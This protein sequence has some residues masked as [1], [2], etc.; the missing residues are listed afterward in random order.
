[1]AMLTEAA[2]PA[3]FWPYA[4]EAYT[5]V[6]NRTCTSALEPTKTPFEIWYGRKPDVSHLRVFGSLAYT[7][8]PADLRKSFDSHYA[9]AICLGYSDTKPGC[10]RFYNAEKGVH[11]E[12]SQAVFD[13]HAFPGNSRAPIDLF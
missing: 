3:A 11:F 12:S 1:T 13:E 5:Y 10:W 4:V 2:L 7:L 9:K 8:V 6:H